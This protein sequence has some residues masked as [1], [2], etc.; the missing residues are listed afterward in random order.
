MVPTTAVTENKF[1]SVSHKIL[2]M[3]MPK[4]KKSLAWTNAFTCSYTTTAHFFK[5]VF[6]C[7]VCLPLMANSCKY[8][9]MKIIQLCLL[10]S[11]FLTATFISKVKK[12]LYINQNNMYLKAL[13]VCNK[14]I[15]QLMFTEY[16]LTFV[17]LSTGWR[18]AF[19][20]YQKPLFGKPA[21]CLIFTIC[22]SKQEDH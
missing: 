18:N 12:F 2:K 4:T 6:S 14:Q 9:F 20:F 22:L 11:N 10:C 7:K 13:N 1:S 3:Q 8:L 21:S 5:T 19:S 17:T 16:N 15:K